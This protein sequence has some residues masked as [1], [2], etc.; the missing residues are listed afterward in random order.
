MRGVMDKQL[1]LGTLVFCISIFSGNIANS[2]ET[3]MGDLRTATPLSMH[4]ENLSIDE[5]VQLLESKVESHEKALADKLNECR[6]EYRKLG[7][8]ATWCPDGSVVTEVEKIYGTD[9]LNVSCA[10]PILNCEK[11]GIQ[12]EL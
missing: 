9:M 1:G 5:R 2:A 7:R 8:R 11:L 3:R 12:I 10:R 6:L 4:S